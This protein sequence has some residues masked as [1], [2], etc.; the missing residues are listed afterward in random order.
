MNAKPLPTSILPITSKVQA[1]STAVK[2][3]LSR[4]ALASILLQALPASAHGPTV[5]D[6]SAVSLLPVAMLAAAP[7]FILSG[8]MILTVVSV[9]ASATSTV[10]MLERASDG[11]RLSLTVAGNSVAVAG[12]AVIVTAVSA[13]WVLS[14]AAK[15]IAFVPNEIG[16]S[17]LYNERVTQ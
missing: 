2:R 14:T 8:G 17:L 4:L 10:W 6:A 12:A 7:A 3:G 15:A 16:A 9:Q 11:A 1:L 13:G 5:S